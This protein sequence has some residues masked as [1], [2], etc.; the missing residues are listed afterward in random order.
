MKNMW[1]LVALALTSASLAF[2]QADLKSLSLAELMDVQVT[3]VS[4][5]PEQLSEVASAIQVITAEDIR[6][7]GATSLPEALRLATNLQVAQSNAHGWAITARGFNGAPLSNNSLADKL[8]VLVYGRS[9]YTP[10]FGGVFWDV[11]AVLLED[12]D[13]IEV[14]SGP[15][16]TLWGANA[17]NGVINIVTK[18]VKDT[19]GAYA[20]VLFGSFVKDQESARVGHEIAKGLHLRLYAQHTDHRSTTLQN[21][22]DATDGWNMTQGG[23]RL[24]YEREDATGSVI[25]NF[26]GGDQNLSTIQ[27]DGQNILGRYTQSLGEK[28]DV[29]VQA[30]FD[31]TWRRLEP[32]GFSDEMLTYDL[33]GLCT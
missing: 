2:A 17:V 18:P 12:I 27:L 22:K 14:I 9:I 1:K 20:S 21:G 4:K 30:Y 10:L 25:G 24:D 31:R 16:G 3:S 7:S 23:F 19:E 26:Y 11:Q 28:S 33:D 15:G 6:R 29:S 5:R 13:R 32:P 8:L